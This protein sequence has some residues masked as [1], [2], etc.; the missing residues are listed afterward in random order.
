MAIISMDQGIMYDDS[1]NIRN[2][3]QDIYGSEDP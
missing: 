1:H 3:N 2:K